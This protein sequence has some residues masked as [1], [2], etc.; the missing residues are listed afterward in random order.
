[1]G[2]GLTILCDLDISI[3]F[4]L[5]GSCFGVTGTMHSQLG[6]RN[7]ERVRC[8][9][10]NSIPTDILSRPIYPSGFLL[11]PSFIR[12]RHL[13]ELR[14]RGRQSRTPSIPLFFSSFISDGAWGPWGL[15]NWDC[16]SRST[17]FPESVPVDCST[18]KTK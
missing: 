13:L 3:L 15:A 8:A 14:I 16:L 4:E 12:M 5:A 1:M 6:I 10:R 2:G 11:P 7:E 17:L 18:D 9:P